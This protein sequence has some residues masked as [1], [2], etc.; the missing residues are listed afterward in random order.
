LAK[1]NEAEGSRLYNKPI[2]WPFRRQQPQDLPGMTVNTDGSIDFTI[3][4]EEQQAVDSFFQMLEG[5][6]LHPEIA[7]VMPK[8]GM[9][10]A[11][12][13]YAI[14]LVA[15]LI[16]IETDAEYMSK[17]AEIQ[18]RLNRAL[19]ATYK[20]SSLYNLPAFT[21]HLASFNDMAGRTAEAQRLNALYAKKQAT[22]TPSQLDQLLLNWL[23]H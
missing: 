18:S 5:Y 19:A 4:D 15:P 6:K 3:T 1:F 11:L 13:R 22:W 14:D 8:A 20:A 10:C 12:C 7:D 21:H 16:A 9:A 2:M 17:Q 23:E